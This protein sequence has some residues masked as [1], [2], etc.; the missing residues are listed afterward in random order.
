MYKA[1]KTVEDYV[2]EIKAASDADW[3]KR[4]Y[5]MKFAPT[6]EIMPGSKFYRIVII[7]GY[8]GMCG[9]SVHCFVDKQGNIFKSASW[10]IPAK[11]IRGNINDIKKPLLGWDY[12]NYKY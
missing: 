9:R 8:G 5:D 1:M 4:G 6:F 10:K 12:Y 7:S 11:G 3:V 2:K